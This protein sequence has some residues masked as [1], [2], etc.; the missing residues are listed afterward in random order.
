MDSGPHRTRRVL[1]AF[2]ILLAAAFLLY[3]KNFSNE[4]TYDDYSV[5]VHNPDIQS[6]E[7]FSEGQR[8]GRPVR[9]LS[10]L[11]DYRFFKLDP[12][13]YHIQNIFWHGLNAFLIFY[14]ITG[15]TCDRRIAWAASLLFLVHPVNV[16]VVAQISHRKD[17]LVLA[18]CL[19]SFISFIKAVHS[20]RRRFPWLLVC[21]VA[22]VTAYF[23][24]ENAAAL[25]IVFL[26]YLLV[27]VDTGGRLAKYKL[28][29]LG[30]LGIAGAV[31]LVWYL[32]FNG[33]DI[34]LEKVRIALGRMN[35]FGPVSESVYLRMV[36]KSWLF[37]FSKFVIPT[38]L[39]LE[40]Q[41]PVPESWLD[42][43]VIGAV[44][45]TAAWGVALVFA[46]QRSPTA[47]VALVWLGAFWLP[48]SNLWPITN[49]FM[50]DR[51]LYAPL[52]GVFVLVSMAV[53]RIDRK[54][55]YAGIVVLIAIA[56]LAGLTWK[57]NDVW[58]T[59]C[60]LWQHAADANPKST[61]ALNNL[62]QCFYRKGEHE[63]A[64]ALF[65][66]S[67]E[68]NPYNASPYFNLGLTFEKTGRSELSRHYYLQFISSKDPRYV[69]LIARVKKHLVDIY[70]PE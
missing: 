51:Y 35:Y 62:G 53:F 21:L 6:V 59:H 48:T 22:A 43:W 55:I 56:G 52:V 66:R 19:I 16:E 37:A 13:G 49:R 9:E 1:I 65:L 26:A 69:D 23:A 4:W 46:G 30:V 15:C 61:T 8:P 60:S 2:P 5:L 47:F 36:L 10:Y 67:I 17:S 11:I 40:Y 50:A 58:K 68:A 41:Y 38:G 27:H 33:R 12:S 64:I 31:V 14:L 54:A 18:F 29:L 7:A 24:K 63:R 57:Q 34:F 20:Q 42:L 39:A 25:P 44:L 32:G 3:A 45:L 28:P 70:G